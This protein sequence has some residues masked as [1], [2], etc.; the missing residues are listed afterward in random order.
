[1]DEK[2]I[3]KIIEKHMVDGKLSCAD[4]HHI[5]D[6]NRIHLTTI[7][8]ICNEGEEQIR[9]TKCMLGCF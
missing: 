7:G 8:R 3:R 2:Q 4:A 5:A 9:I 6:E 1:M